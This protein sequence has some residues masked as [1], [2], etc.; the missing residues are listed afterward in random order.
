M[1]VRKWLHNKCEF[2]CRAHSKE[3]WAHLKPIL[4]TELV[5]TFFDPSRKMAVKWCY[6]RLLKTIGG[7]LPMHQDQCQILNAAMP[8][9]K[10]SAW[11]FMAEGP[12][13]C[14]LAEIN[15]DI[16]RMVFSL[17]HLSE[18]PNKRQSHDNLKLTWWTRAESW[19]GPVPLGWKE[20]PV[21]DRSVKLSIENAA[22]QH[23]CAVTCV[24]KHMKSSFARHRIPQIVYSDDGKI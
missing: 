1:H 7:Q 3:D 2:K 8:R 13:T 19:E 22:S 11:N 24:I 4:T 15:A 12:G 14:L 23:V 5:M 18:V 16:D 17:W 9:F 10:K 6:Y 20:L 21:G